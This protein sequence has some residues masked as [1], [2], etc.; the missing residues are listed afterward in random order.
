MHEQLDLLRSFP[1]S[2]FE[3]ESV[4]SDS[5]LEGQALFRLAGCLQGMGAG[6]ASPTCA[7]HMKRERHEIRCR[8]AG[9]DV[10]KPPVQRC[11]PLGV[12]ARQKR[13]SNPIVKNRHPIHAARHGA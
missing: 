1:L 3:G 2:P 4:H 6:F 9:H 7:V 13:R 5:P 10:S 11:D 8:R 12:H